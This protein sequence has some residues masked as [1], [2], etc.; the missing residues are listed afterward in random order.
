MAA[1]SG[2]RPIAVRAMFYWGIDSKLRACNLVKLRA[3]DVAH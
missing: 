1:H 2:F 3:R